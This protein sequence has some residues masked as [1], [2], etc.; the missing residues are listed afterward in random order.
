MTWYAASTLIGMRQI[1]SED[2][3]MEVYE[4]VMLIEAKSHEEILGEYRRR[5]HSERI[6]YLCPTRQ[7]A[8]QAGKE[9]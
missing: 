3:G 4:D 9:K 1:G 7:L 2:E 6:L 5:K 8:Q